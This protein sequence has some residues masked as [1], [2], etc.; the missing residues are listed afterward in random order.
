MSEPIE[1]LELNLRWVSDN[2]T[3]AVVGH[4][5]EGLGEKPYPADVRFTYIDRD[6][7]YVVELEDSHLGNIWTF[8]RAALKDTFMPGF[9][10]RPGSLIGGRTI[11]ATLIRLEDYQAAAIEEDREIEALRLSNGNAY[12]VLRGK[13]I[14]GKVSGSEVGLLFQT[15]DYQGEELRPDELLAPSLVIKNLKAADRAIDRHTLRS[16]E[17][18]ARDKEVAQQFDSLVAKALF[19][20]G[21]PQTRGWRRLLV[22]PYESG[23]SHYIEV[24]RFRYSHKPGDSTRRISIAEVTG[25]HGDTLLVSSYEIH[26]G[27]NKHVVSKRVGFMP[28]TDE[29]RREIMQA[30]VEQMAEAMHD[31]THHH[32]LEFTDDGVKSV[33]GEPRIEGP[34]KYDYNR[35]PIVENFVTNQPQVTLAD[36]TELERLITQVLPL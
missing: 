27:V 10:A 20:H 11:S 21:K 16:A 19:Y 18:V 4:I 25:E 35:S 13:Q 5:R 2:F 23:G 33:Q 15:T 30:G 31:N 34:G 1:P 12:G 26:P 36:I 22:D 8:G 24:D 17:E 32:Y 14:R 6:Q 7:G 3:E 29:V 28:N 9:H